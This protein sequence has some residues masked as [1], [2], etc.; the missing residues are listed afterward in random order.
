MLEPR[1]VNL[2]VHCAILAYIVRAKLV[3]ELQP[4]GVTQDVVKH[5]QLGARLCANK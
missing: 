2:A 1:A 4:T 5:A 3:T